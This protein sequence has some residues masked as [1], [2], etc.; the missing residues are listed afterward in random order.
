MSTMKRLTSRDSVKC[1]S[2]YNLNIT[3]IMRS[4]R[5]LILFCGSWQLA[6]LMSCARESRLSKNSAADPAPPWPGCKG[7][8]PGRAPP[9]AAP[10]PATRPPHQ[11]CRRPLGGRAGIL[12]AQGGHVGHAV[13]T[14]DRRAYRIGRQR[15]P[16]HAPLPPRASCPWQ[17]GKE[18]GGRRRPAARSGSAQPGQRCVGSANSACPPPAAVSNSLK[19][20]V[21][22]DR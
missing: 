13:V 3:Y 20:G 21:Q 11:P 5:F 10:A 4:L 19:P 8:Q 18:R 15:I 17:A 14:D 7:C 2:F 1:L 6:Q 22:I 16:E 12:G 9:A